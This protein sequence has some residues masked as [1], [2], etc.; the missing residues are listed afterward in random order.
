MVNRTIEQ[1]IIPYCI[2]NKLGILAYSPLQRGLLT[3]KIKTGHRFNEGDTRPSTLYY[4]EPNLSRILKL[5]EQLGVIANDHDIT[6]SQL[7]LNWTL[8]QPGITC[9]L[10]GARNVIQVLENVRAADANLKDEDITSIN[11]QLSE[12]KLETKF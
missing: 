2:K 3:G 4:K 5:T 8:R 11:E 1:D 6:L 10:A 12:L 9:V 7:V